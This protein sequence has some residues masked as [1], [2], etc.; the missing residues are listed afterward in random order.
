MAH[1]SNAVSKPG[2]KA[3]A[4]AKR[5]GKSALY[6]VALAL[7]R[8]L[9]FGLLRGRVRGREHIP[10]NGPLVLMCNHIHAL[11]PCTL[12]VC[13]PR[14]QIHFLAKEE[15]FK[16]KLMAWALRRVHAIQVARGRFDMTAMRESLKVLGAGEVLG[17]FPEGHRGD[18]KELQPLQSGA[19]LLA[20][21][22]GAPVTPVFIGGRYRL[23]EGPRVL[24]GPPIQTEDLRAAGIDKDAAETF[25]GRIRDALEA[26]RVEQDSFLGK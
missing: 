4:A 23:F 9:F 15:A 1:E 26:L 12:G 25:S 5:Y 21:R 2:T 17:I 8:L 11:D 3:P 20:L 18:G 13:M 10:P 14:I 16:H 6:G 22:S 19:A 7:Y 24:I